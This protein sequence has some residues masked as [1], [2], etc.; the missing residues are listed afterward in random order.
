MPE[1]PRP[2]K[3]GHPHERAADTALLNLWLKIEDVEERRQLTSYECP[4]GKWHTG[5]LKGAPWE[6]RPER[7][8]RRG[9]KVGRK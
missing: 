9:Q 4:C 2:D 8:K 6:R 7:R 3:V 1:C 5:H